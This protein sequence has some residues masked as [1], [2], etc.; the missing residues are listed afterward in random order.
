[1]ITITLL[2]GGNLATHLA[3]LFIKTPGIQLLQIYNRNLQAISAFKNSTELTDSLNNLKAADI[4][5]ICIADKSI[6]EIADQ[7]TNKKGL[8]VHT[9]GA[10]DIAILGKR[11]KKGVFY[12]LQSF[13]KNKPVDFQHIPIC[14][15]AS[16][17]KDVLLL[18]DL[19]EKISTKVYR[20]DSSQ[21]KTLHIAA[22]FV[23]NFV[24]HLYKIGE[25]ICT[26]NKIPFEILH[27]L[28]LETATKLNKLSPTEAQTGPASRNDQETIKIHESK[29]D[30]QQKEIYQLLTA[31]ILKT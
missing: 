8:L 23:N 3:E 27:P 13:S 26:E 18:K 17:E 19:A 25:D 24:N 14:I 9:S 11:E 31:A 7:L 16:T 22:V 30:L 5:I 28:I 6:K 4:Y 29:L 1:M 15:E 12:P 21:R 2:G 20:I 10:M